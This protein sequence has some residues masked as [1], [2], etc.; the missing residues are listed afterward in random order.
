MNNPIDSNIV[1]LF[2]KTIPEIIMTMWISS[3]LEKNQNYQQLL[4]EEIFSDDDFE[5]LHLPITFVK[6][7]VLQIYQKLKIIQKELTSNP[8]ITHLELFQKVEP[9]LYYY[10]Q[11]IKLKIDLHNAHASFKRLNRDAH[12]AS[13]MLNCITELYSARPPPFEDIFS[14]LLKQKEIENDVYENLSEKLKANTIPV[15]RFEEERF[16]NVI[17]ELQSFLCSLDYQHFDYNTHI[18]FLSNLGEFKVLDRLT[19]RNS[20]LLDYVMLLRFLD[21][22]SSLKEL[23]LIACTN[24][25]P[26]TRKLLQE[27]FPNLSCNIY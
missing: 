7:T 20:T 4:N 5:N 10:Y 26:N 21:R 13:L 1:S 12:L 3:I 19:I 27:K 18:L 23:T 2:L 24:I 6:G 14:L 17:E 15:F 22:M 11:G 25:D 9:L 8:N 16:T